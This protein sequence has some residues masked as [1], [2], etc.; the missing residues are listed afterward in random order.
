MKKIIFNVSIILTFSVSLFSCK[1]ILIEENIPYKP[2]SC[3]NQ[4]WQTMNNK[5]TFFD[6]KHVNWDSIKTVYEPQVNDNMS[7]EQLFD[8]L[9]K[10]LG[11]V[12]DGHTSLY[13]PNDTFRYYYANGYNKNYDENFV[14][15]KYLIPNNFSTTETM[16]FCMLNGNIGYIHYP[17]FKNELTQNGIDGVLNSFSSTKGLIIDIRNNTGGDNKNIIR[18]IEHFVSTTTKVGKSIE[19]KDAN[20]NSFTEPID[21]SIAP[22]GVNYTKPIMILT[23]RT[24][25]SSA[26]IFTG[27]MSQLPQVKIIGDITGGGTGL[28]TSD[29]L[30]NGWRFRYSSSII[31]LANGADFEDGLLPTISITTD[32][33][34]QTSTGKDAII[35]RAIVEIQ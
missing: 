20:K 5:Y 14:K 22:K 26:N 3:F 17:S 28:P 25:F 29:N 27:F 33:I 6:Y 15:E 21:I 11:S 16:D 35:E 34:S 24:V 19:K 8:V 2:I 1:K 13:A 30:P 18:L 32:S 4:L 12:R 10:M 9:A 31:R 23:N 7:E